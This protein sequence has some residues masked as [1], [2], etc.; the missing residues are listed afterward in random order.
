MKR[1]SK[2]NVLAS[3]NGSLNSLNNNVKKVVQNDLIV[4]TL[5]VLLII[6]SSFVVPQMS[7]REANVV[8]NNIVRLIIVSLI[9]YLGFIDMV[10]AVLL[11]IAFVVTMHLSLI[12][13]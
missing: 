10:T 7:N 5:R 13:I 6:Y 12:H 3:V 4:N 1:N 8:N 11:L 9:V 2:N